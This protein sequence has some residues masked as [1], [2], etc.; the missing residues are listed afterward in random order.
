LS[1]LHGSGTTDDTK[2]LRFGG[3]DDDDHISFGGGIGVDS[4][5]SQKFNSFLQRQLTRSLAKK[6]NAETQINPNIIRSQQVKPHSIT[7]SPAYQKYNC[8]NSQQYNSMNPNTFKIS[9]I[10]S[11]NAATHAFSRLND[12]GST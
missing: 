4:P 8:F 3:L 12:E 6:L 5:K 10:F 7:N 11:P 1:N 9:P 2:N